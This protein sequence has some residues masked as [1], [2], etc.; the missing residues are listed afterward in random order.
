MTAEQDV[1]FLPLAMRCLV[2]LPQY[3][4]VLRFPYFPL[5]RLFRMQLLFAA[6]CKC[7]VFYL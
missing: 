6:I 3:N 4:Q 2:L 5:L 1:F 7:K